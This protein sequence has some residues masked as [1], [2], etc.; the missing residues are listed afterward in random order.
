MEIPT[1]T[2]L[3]GH[4]D[5]ILSLTSTVGAALDAD[6]LRVANPNI[7]SDNTYYAFKRGT[8]TFLELARIF[9]FGGSET[10]DIIE[11]A[12]TGEMSLLAP[13]CRI[14][15]SG[16]LHETFAATLATSLHCC[17][18]RERGRVFSRYTVT[19]R[20]ANALRRMP[21]PAVLA[22]KVECISVLDVLGAVV[23]CEEGNSGWF[24]DSAEMEMGIPRL[25]GGVPDAAT[26]AQAVGHGQMHVSFF[27]L[28][29]ARGMRV[30]RA[31]SAGPAVY[32]RDGARACEMIEGLAGPLVGESLRALMEGPGEAA[33]AG[34]Q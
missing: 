17:R 20:F 8:V 33:P 7:G 31:E 28:E 21:A 30:G 13:G 27:T 16:E 32:I 2:L 26:I 3:C 15:Y 11:D 9:Q 18:V 4:S 5:A 23:C 12:A 6:V 25:G 19:D 34:M 1:F 24:V 29:G 22:E 14:A 10:F